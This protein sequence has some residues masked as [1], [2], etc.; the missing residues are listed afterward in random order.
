[1]KKNDYL[2]LLN[3]ILLF[4]CLFSGESLGTTGCSSPYPT[5]VSLDSSIPFSTS[6]LLTDSAL[7]CDNLWFDALLPTSSVCPLISTSISGYVLNVLNAF[8]S[9]ASDS[10]VISAL[11]VAKVIPSRIIGTPTF[12]TSSSGLRGSV[13]LLTSIPS[14]TVPPSVSGLSGSVL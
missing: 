1:Y 2:I 7:C 8:C 5:A 4:F 10:G 14:S 3:S 6:H 11:P 12:T 9:V 13:S